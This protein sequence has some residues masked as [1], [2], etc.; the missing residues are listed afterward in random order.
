MDILLEKGMALDEMGQGCPFNQAE[1]LHAAYS[2]SVPRWVWF[3]ELRIQI[4]L[5][6]NPKWK[7]P[8][9]ELKQASSILSMPV[10]MSPLAHAS[11][12]SGRIS[13]KTVIQPTWLIS[14]LSSYIYIKV[15]FSVRSLWSFDLN[16]YQPSNTLLLPS[17]LYFSQDKLT[18]FNIHSVLFVISSF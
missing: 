3:Q 18:L 11:Y 14:S 1:F 17:L 16:A 7:L 9:L 10:S 15:I 8:T 12:L 5:Q 4:F 13:P 6:H 2:I